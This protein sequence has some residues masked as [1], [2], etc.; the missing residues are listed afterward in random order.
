MK[1]LPRFI[2]SVVAGAGIA[3]L[4]SFVFGFEL[5]ISAIFGIGSFL[6]SLL[7]L[8]PKKIDPV[9]EELARMHGITPGK[10]KSIIKDGRKKVRKMRHYAKKIESEKVNKKIEDICCIVENIYK[11]FEH[12]PK[13]VKAA[14]QFLNYYLDATL[15]IIMQYYNLSKQPSLTETEQKTFKKVEK[16]L[17]TIEK[18]FEQQ[19]KK[20]YEDDFFDLDTEIEV[21]EK[22][23]KL[24]TM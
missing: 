8:A 12:D 4:F 21:L 2:L 6:G 7:L 11:D 16:T 14:R 24:D 23:M 10:L 20:L 3:A 13:D 17:N 22:T 18:T 15:K 5:L 19:L 9:L 1:G